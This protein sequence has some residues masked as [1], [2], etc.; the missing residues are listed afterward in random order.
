MTNEPNP[1]DPIATIKIHGR[2]DHELRGPVT[3]GRDPRTDDGA[4]VV[5]DGDP[6]VSKSHLCVDIDQGELVVT[7]LGSSNGTY[8]HHPAGEVVV[9]SDRWIPIPAGVEIEFGDQRMTIERF[10]PGG[11]VDPDITPVSSHR[12]ESDEGTA[13]PN[14]ARVAPA[15]APP[16]VEEP[17]HTVVLPPGGPAPAAPTPAPHY[18]QPPA[19]ARS[20]PAP[21]PAPAR[22]QQPQH[23]QQP[24]QFGQ[25]PP[26]TNGPVFVD[27]AVTRSSNSGAGKK[28]LLGVGA[29]IVAGLVLGGLAVVLGGDDTDSM[30]L[31]FPRAPE[32]VEEQWS[33]EVDGASG[34]A[35]IGE[36]SVYVFSVVD[37]VVVITGLDREDGDDLWET[38][39]DRAEF[40]R[41]VG[42]F[43]DVAVVEACVED[44]PNDCAVVGLDRADGDEIW[45][46]Q[47][48]D[49]TALEVEANLLFLADDGIA[50]LDPENGERLERLN[51]DVLGG[52]NGL[53]IDEGGE[54]AAYDVGLGPLWGPYEIDDDAT[55]FSFDGDSTGRRDRRRDRVRRRRRKRHPRGRPSTVT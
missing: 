8:L 23:G 1:G 43:G 50:S 7:D 40:A 9:P 35:G 11:P 13:A 37:D 52:I 34:F 16:S 33:T 42:E 5:V 48:G 14:D 55:A 17:G 24:L 12:V 22:S 18:G 39:I 4:T 38:A 32:D 6:L 45:R 25:Q 26:P 41:F 10:V 46:E 3:I 19:P 53:L 27:P 31:S 36:N 54:I 21:A 15:T 30:P 47:L 29:L 49:I 44:T 28:I 2:S 51:G 20:A